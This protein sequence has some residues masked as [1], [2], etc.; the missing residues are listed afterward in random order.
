MNKYRKIIILI[1]IYFFTNLSF[2]AFGETLIIPKKKP[3]IS[4]ERKVISE[5]K[6][7]ILPLKKPSLE[8]KK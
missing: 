7:E 2:S 1:T 6:T 4:V 8:E 5:L 3:Q